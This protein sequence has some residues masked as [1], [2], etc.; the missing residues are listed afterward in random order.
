MSDM[1]P[2][3]GSIHVNE[4]VSPHSILRKSNEIDVDNTI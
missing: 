3:N 4:S 2:G 1:A